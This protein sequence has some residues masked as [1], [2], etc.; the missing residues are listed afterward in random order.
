MY[1]AEKYILTGLA[2]GCVDWMER[3]ISNENACAILE[4][5]LLHRKEDLATRSRQYILQNVVNVVNDPSFVKLPHGLLNELLSSDELYAQEVVIYEACL[6]WAK[7]K[8]SERGEDATGS[9]IRQALGDC[10]QLVRFPL[11]KPSMFVDLMEKC[12]NVLTKDEENSLMKYYISEKQTS[13]SNN[14]RVSL[15][16]Y[17]V[18]RFKSVYQR[19]TWKCNDGKADAIS[20][21]CDRSIHMNGI[22]V[23]GNENSSP[24]KLEVEVCGQDDKAIYEETKDMFPSSGKQNPTHLCFSKEIII[25]PNLNYTIIQRMWGSDVYYG[26]EGLKNVSSRGVTFKFSESPLSTNNTKVNYGQIPGLL[27]KLVNSN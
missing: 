6:K 12:P 11:M 21:K 7:Y 25:S 4:C 1:A 20:F 5:A 15:E 2:S 19:T 9:A 22:T 3:N 13:F 10:L 17:C 16:T 14:R 27:F 23:Y 24:H 26:N 8:C 18:Q